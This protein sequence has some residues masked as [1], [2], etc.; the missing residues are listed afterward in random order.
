MNSPERARRPDATRQFSRKVRQ[1]ISG[2]PERLTPKEEAEA[3]RLNGFSIAR[4]YTTFQLKRD[5]YFPP[6]LGEA[7]FDILIDLFL[8]EW[9]N[10]RVGSAQGGGMRLASDGAGPPA[11]VTALVDAGLAI[12]TQSGGPTEEPVRV[13]NLSRSG[14][15]RLNVFFDYM[16]NY[17]SAV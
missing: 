10:R 3:R 15:A 16:A 9:L 7:A 13:I 12:V 1:R 8:Y 11:G 2:I 4:I 17:I 5:E 6:E 14:R